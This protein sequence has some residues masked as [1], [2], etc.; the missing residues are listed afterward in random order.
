MDAVIE[1]RVISREQ[2]TYTT[3][4]GEERTVGTYYALIGDWPRPVKLEGQVS[5][6][7]EVGNVYELEVLIRRPKSDRPGLDVWI[8]DIISSRAA[9]A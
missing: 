3:R 2:R 6:A 9:A 5:L 8:R 7:L 1:A 4:T